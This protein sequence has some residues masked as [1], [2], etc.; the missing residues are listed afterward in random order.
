MRLI[1]VVIFVFGF[2]IWDISLNDGYYAR[3]INGYLYDF[4]REVR[5]R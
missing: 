1:L 4:A 2:L 5:W 3:H